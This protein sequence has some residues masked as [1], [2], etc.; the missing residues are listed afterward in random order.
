M[1]ILNINGEIY[2]N[3]KT[4]I[5]NNFLKFSYVFTNA[6]IRWNFNIIN[7]LCLIIFPSSTGTVR[8]MD[9]S[10]SVE[11]KAMYILT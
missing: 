11:H 4:L 10:L 9:H 8:D 3:Q 1:Q 6:P 7:V 5:K 2:S